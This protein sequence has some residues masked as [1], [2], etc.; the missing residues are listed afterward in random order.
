MH[1]HTFWT[2]AENSADWI[3]HKIF[4][5][6]VVLGP[7]GQVFTLSCRADINFVFFIITLKSTVLLWVQPAIVLHTLML[8]SSS[9]T[10]CV[11]NQKQTRR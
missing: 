5:Y 7:V 3:Q 1:F 6:Q 2:I 8:K 11:F 4:L 9:T 10:T